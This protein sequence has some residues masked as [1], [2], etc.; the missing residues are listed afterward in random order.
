MNISLH[1]SAE[2]QAELQRRAAAAGSDLPAF[3]LQ[4]VFEKLAEQNG[5]PGD[6]APYE[7]WHNE[8]RSWIAAQHSRN[9]G[10]DDSRDSIYN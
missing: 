9:P 1:L 2:E 6:A 4:A 3:I 7:Q 5:P 8:F 10:F